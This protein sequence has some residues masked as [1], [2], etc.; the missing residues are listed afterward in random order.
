MEESAS[1]PEN[2][3][4]TKWT[5]VAQARGDDTTAQAAL[6]DLC[7]DYY[8]P[9]ENF[10]Q[11]WCRNTELTKD[12]TQEFFRQILAKK[13][14]D[15]AD[16]ERG[17]F[18]NYLLGAVKHFLSRT[19]EAENAAKRGGG[20]LHESL[21]GASETS[22]EIPIPDTLT[23]PPDAHFDRVWAMTA[24][25]MAII[26]LQREF[27]D[28]GRERQFEVLKHWLTGAEQSQAEAAA[29][30]DMSETAVKVA[31]HRLRQRFRQAIRRHLAQT[32]APGVDVDEEMRHL[33]RALVAEVV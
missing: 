16:R 11:S 7:A 23:L 25:D 3:H 32:L 18:R 27:A 33:L 31:I 24:L 12:L 4:T 22:V 17:R 30:L 13:S 20:V 15:G 9:V 26:A 1:L 2:F 5:R 6:S 28:E 29:Q 14:L 10:I 21:E 19:R 8:A